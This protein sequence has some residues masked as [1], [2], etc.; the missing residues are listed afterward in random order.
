MG[1]LDDIWQLD[2]EKME[3]S[4]SDLAGFELE[5]YHRHQCISYKVPRNLCKLRMPL[6]SFELSQGRGEVF[7]RGFDLEIEVECLE[8]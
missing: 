2:L 8:N 1:Y 6:F 7:V 3:T 4:T 5:T